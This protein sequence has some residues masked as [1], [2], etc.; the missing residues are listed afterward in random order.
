[1]AQAAGIAKRSATIVE[2]SDRMTE[3]IA[4]RR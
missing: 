1:M 4:K 2:P 3:F